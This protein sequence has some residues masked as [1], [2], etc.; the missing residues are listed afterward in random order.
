MKLKRTIQVMVLALASISSTVFATGQIADTF[1]FKGNEY[2]LI[3]K[4]EGDFA[5]PKQFGMTPVMIH[6]ACWRGF[7]ATYELTDEGFFLRELTLRVEDGNYLPIDGVEPDT[8]TKKHQATYTNL[9]VQARFSGKIRLAKDF[10][11]ELYIHMGFQKPTAFKTV[12]DITLKDGKVVDIKNRSEEME[13]KRGE[14]KK[15]FEA[16]ETRQ[17]IEEAFSLDMKLE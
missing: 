10:I 7:Y 1:M 4:T 9:N 5:T 17:S 6:T 11:R 3:G 16:G 14:F 13:A 8:E 2:S 12:L 15:R